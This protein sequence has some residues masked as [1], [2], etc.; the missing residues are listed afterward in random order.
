M[1]C[2]P[3]GTAGRRFDGFQPERRWTSDA[4]AGTIAQNRLHPL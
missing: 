3:E 2:A 4:A 1:A